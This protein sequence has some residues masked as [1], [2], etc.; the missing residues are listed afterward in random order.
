VGTFAGDHV[1]HPPGIL[2]RHGAQAGKVLHRYLF[3]KVP[4]NPEISLI[5]AL[6][7]SCARSLTGSQVIQVHVD[8]VA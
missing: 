4:E 3:V 8:G 1:K 7:G 6:P 2:F 5:A